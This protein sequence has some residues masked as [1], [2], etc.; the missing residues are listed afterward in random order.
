MPMADAPPQLDLEARR[1][2]I[3]YQ[4]WHRGTREMDLV[5]GRF[6]DAQLAVM[7]EAEVGAFEQLLEEAD[8]EL[9]DWVTGRAE[10]PARYQEGLFA[11]I[12]AFHAE[13][14]IC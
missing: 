13:G 2:R 14:G 12:K 11:R 10:T 7:S 8:R 5:M 9:F 4:A 3:R 1:R 6:A